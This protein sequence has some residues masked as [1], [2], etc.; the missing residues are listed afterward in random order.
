M[1]EGLGFQTLPHT[2]SMAGSIRVLLLDLLV[3]RAEF[4]HGGNQEVIRPLLEKTDVEVLLL[5]PQMQSFES[6]LKT[7]LEV[8]V[9]LKPEDVPH[10]DDEYPFWENNIVE[11][12]YPDYLRDLKEFTHN[13]GD[14]YYGDDDDY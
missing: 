8:D 4:G 12:E 5:T 2:M 11:L 1:Q 14:V 9:P 6:G 13:D 10:W 3:E 7:D